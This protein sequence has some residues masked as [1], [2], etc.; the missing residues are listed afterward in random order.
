ML[1]ALHGYLLSVSFIPPSFSALDLLFV[2]NLQLLPTKL[3]YVCL[4]Q[5]HFFCMPF[6][7]AVQ[8]HIF[9]PAFYPANPSSPFLSTFPS[10]LA[11]SL[12]TLHHFGFS[13][14]RIMTW[15]WSWSHLPHCWSSTKNLHT[16]TRCMWKFPLSPSTSRRHQILLPAYFWN[17]WSDLNSCLPHCWL[18]WTHRVTMWSTQLLLLAGAEAANNY[19]VVFF[20]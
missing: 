2:N 15:L 5:N 7:G 10:S 6:S 17:T 4:S 19:R 3:L 11:L 18:Y 14:G 20:F 13:L 9:H 8:L 16:C 12:Y 1:S